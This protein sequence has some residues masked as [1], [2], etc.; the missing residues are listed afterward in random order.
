MLKKFFLMAL[1]ILSCALVLAAHKK[2]I[3]DSADVVITFNNNSNQ[4]K[5]VD[6]VLVI[7]D[8]YD[9]SGAGIVKQ[10]F[11]P[12]GNQIAVV[13]PKGKYFVDVYCLQGPEK[14]HF[15]AVLKARRKKRNKLLFRLRP[16]AFFTPGMVILPEEKID[17]AN[18]SITRL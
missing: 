10:V 14:E 16:S 15:G 11:Y 2:V 3:R 13:I 9:L 4:D 17:L 8:K 7:F 6:S 12:V 18:L 1:S 5:P